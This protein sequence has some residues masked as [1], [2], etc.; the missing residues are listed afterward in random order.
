[1]PRSFDMSAH[2]P[3]TVEQV[4]QA[5]RQEDYWL[6]RL[7]DSGVDHARLEWMQ[8]GGPSGTDGSINVIT[9]QVLREQR[10]PN[11]VTQFHRGDLCIR[12][13]ESW[14][15][16]TGGTANVTVAGSILNAPVKLV[17][18]AALAPHPQSVGVRLTCR[19][20][21]EVRIPFVGGKLENIIGSQLATLVLAEQRFTTM[22]ITENA[23]HSSS[24]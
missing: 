17:S 24:G 9:V 21:V 8:V 3:G 22:W 1:M 19:A 20:T 2:Y 18:T 7:A 11:L 12:R 10:L 6:A 15:P 5:F 23:R 16:I 4:H 13:E 14:T